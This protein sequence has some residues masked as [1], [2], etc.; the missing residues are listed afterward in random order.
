M[1]PLLAALIP[2]IVGA[3]GSAIRGQSKVID[4]ALDVV[5]DVVGHPV[6][7]LDDVD[8][9]KLTNDQILKLKEID[10]AY[11]Y[12]VFKAETDDAAN[13]RQREIEIV[14]SGRIDWSKHFVTITI[15]FG[16]FLT[17]IYILHLVALNEVSTDEAVIVG[18]IITLLGGLLVKVAE[19]YYGKDKK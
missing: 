11:Q 16:Y 19:G 9:S 7:S 10:S 18:Q 6:N 14:K 17:I 2:S 4:S 15:V 1:F 3:V 13:A 8:L 5:Q 12:N